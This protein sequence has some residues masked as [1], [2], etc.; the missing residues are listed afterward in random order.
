MAAERA[1][2]Y[3]DLSIHGWALVELVEAAVRSGRHEVATAAHRE[4][5]AR[6]DAGGTDWAAGT[7]ARS[8]GAKV[9]ER[10]CARAVELTAQEA[11]IAHL[12]REGLTNPEIGLELYLSP[13]TV[14]WHLRKIFAKLAVTSRVELRRRVPLIGPPGLPGCA[15]CTGRD[16]QGAARVRP[17]T[18][19]DDDG[20]TARTLLPTNLSRAPKP[21]PS[22]RGRVVMRLSGSTLE[23]PEADFVHIRPRL[24]GIAYRVLGGAAD[25]EDVVQDV[26][27]RWQ[28]AD[29]AQV[30]DRTG[31]LVTTATRAALNVA[32]SAH[33]R[34]EI[35]IGD[36]MPEPG[37]ASHDPATDAERSEA[38]E[39][40]V[41]LLLERLSPLERAVFVLR[42]AFD[43]PFGLIAEVLAVSE[44]NARQLARRARLRLAG[45]RRARVDPRERSRLLAAFLAAARSGETAS[46]EQVLIG[47]I[48]RQEAS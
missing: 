20:R 17:A 28:G 36:R 48:G 45:P 14:E 30:R 21:G 31:F 27:I 33:A 10:T 38:L 7:E 22:G 46:L 25:A 47:T 24:F 39:L 44:P 4:L 15:Q 26:W 19:A 35:S 32:T 40:A 29:R 12:A 8:A 11:R 37:G 18:P 13:R 34:R 2:E 43:Y 23:P 6:T 9:Q 41:A 1:C 16:P 3:D 42:E 5:A